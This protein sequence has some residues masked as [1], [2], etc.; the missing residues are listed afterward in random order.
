MQTCSANRTM[1]Y[2]KFSFSAAPTREQGEKGGTSAIHDRFYS[3]LSPLPLYL[4]LTAVSTCIHCTFD[5]EGVKHELLL[6]THT[7]CIFGCFYSLAVL[8]HMRHNIRV[9]DAMSA[10]LRKKMHFAEYIFVRLYT[11][12]CSQAGCI[13]HAQS[14]V[15]NVWCLNKIKLTRMNITGDIYLLLTF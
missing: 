7:L 4:T 9:C 14:N 10:H 3:T 5:A 2:N 1:R 12:G 15:K 11:N 8:R 6:Q 13:E